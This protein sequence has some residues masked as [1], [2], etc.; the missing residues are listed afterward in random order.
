MLESCD[1]SLK[2]WCDS[3]RFEALTGA[4]YIMECLRCGGFLPWAWGAGGI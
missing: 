4:E 1:H 2:D 3:Q